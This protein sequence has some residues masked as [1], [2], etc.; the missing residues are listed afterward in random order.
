MNINELIKIVEKKIKN[1]IVLESIRVE[2]KSFLHKDHKGNQKDKFHLKIIINSK[3]LENF[4][5]I[6]NTKKIYK[7]LDNEIK[8]FIHSIQILIN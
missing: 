2:D 7:I 6:E 3:E 1:Q 5:K 4:T 8:H